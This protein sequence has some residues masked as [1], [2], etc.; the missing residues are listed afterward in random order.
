MQHRLWGGWLAAGAAALALALPSAAAA[1]WRRGETAHFVVYSN[2]SER[3]LRDYAAR[4]ERFHALLRTVTRAAQ[5]DEDLRKLPVYL[6]D[7]ARELRIVQPGLPEGVD[8]YYSAGHQDIRAALIR[9]R[10]DDLLLHEY[11]HHFMSHYSPGSYPAWFREGFAEYFATATVDSRGRSTFGYPG[12][13]RLQT[14]HQQRWMP[15]EQLLT[16]SPMEL[17]RQGQRWAYY[18]QSWLLTHYFLSDAG[19]QR[20]LDAYL[21]ALRAGADPLDAFFGNVGTTPE[22]LTRTLRSYY[23]RGMRYSELTLPPLAPEITVTR[24]PESADDVLL[25]GVDM[26]D[27]A[28]EDRGPELLAASRAAAARHPGDALALTVLARAEIAWGDAAAGDAALRQVLEIE[29]DNVEALLMAAERRIEAAHEEVEQDA[30]LA[31]YREAQSL[32]GRAYQADPTDYRVLAEL[33]MLRQSAPDYPTENDLQT[34]R[35]AVRHAPQVLGLR[36]QA[37]TA[38]LRAGL[39]DEAALHLTPLADDPHGGEFAE[40]ARAQIERIRER[41]AA[42]GAEAEVSGQPVD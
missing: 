16:A 5:D 24:M 14:L 18:A 34:W 22:D 7:N 9:G 27:G 20:Q 26:R 3:N 32:L 4:L 10:D 6:V 35:L 33:A 17:E 1:E 21:R 19:R 31:G 15:L 28:D 13:G 40:R 30:L 25:I 39:T 12:L 2:G 23:Q 37:A 36:A 38:L 8:G 29:P 11:T 41:P 42:S